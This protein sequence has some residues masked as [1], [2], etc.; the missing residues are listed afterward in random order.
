M[1]FC[2]AVATPSKDHVSFKCRE[3]GIHLH[4]SVRTST[5]GA[6]PLMR[7]KSFGRAY[8]TRV[9]TNTFLVLNFFPMSSEAL[10]FEYHLDGSPVVRFLIATHERI[11][12]R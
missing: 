2:G 3:S 8:E 6:T 5:L 4:E 9:A 11:L 7:G 10:V 1:A 12:W